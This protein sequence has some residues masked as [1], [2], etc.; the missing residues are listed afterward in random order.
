M[1]KNPFYVL[2]TLLILG[3]S[4]SISAQPGGKIKG[5]EK[6]MPEGEFGIDYNVTDAKGKRQGPW[7]RVY[8][9]GSIYYLGQ[10]SDG[11]PSGEFWF[12]YETGEVMS[13]VNHLDGTK[14]MEAVNYH[15]NG[16]PQS[17][18]AYREKMVGNKLEK[19]K[20]GQWMFYT[21]QGILKTKEN[22]NMGVQEGMSLTF[23][24]TGKTLLESEYANNMKNGPCTEYFADGTVKMKAG[25]KDDN[26]DGPIELF[27]PGRKPYVRGN[28]KNGLKDGL[29]FYFNT[30]GTINITTKFEE[31]VEIATK[32][33]NGE[34]TD[35]HDSGIP[36]A[37]LTY[38][39]GELNG[40]FSEMFDLGEWVKEPMEEPQPGGGIQF[41]ETLKGTQVEREGDYL[42][43]KLEGPVTYYNERGRIMKIEHYVDG[44]LE[45]TEEK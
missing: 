42:D 43:G 26:F 20:D 11:N 25:Y 38:E 4:T 6:K 24:E 9:D 32:R 37:Y 15:R 22:Y 45:S 33:E 28:Y 2:F 3:L 27:K 41:K 44:E 21:D 5:P 12:W 40:P 23:F 29:W 8:Q 19:V 18:G 1:M 17:S 13:K 16:Y 36:K 30:D 10:F 35:Y 7:V 34:F 14:H 39:E 31:G